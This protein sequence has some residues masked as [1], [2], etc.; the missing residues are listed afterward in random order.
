MMLC[1][2][3]KFQLQV[4]T[5]D[6]SIWAL[7]QEDLR[8]GPSE[9]VQLVQMVIKVFKLFYFFLSQNASD[10]SWGDQL[11][12]LSWDWRF[13]RRWNF[14]VLK[15]GKSQTTWGELI[16]LISLLSVTTWLPQHQASH[17]KCAIFSHD[18]LYQE[19]NSLSLKCQS[20]FLC[21]SLTR[22][23]SHAY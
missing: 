5:H 11:S 23:G 17:R 12:Q 9:L 7:A 18:S 20:T 13:P 15:V 3:C 14:L 22:T 10:V 2:S 1:S 6:E 16:I 21:I 8:M 19:E 4:M